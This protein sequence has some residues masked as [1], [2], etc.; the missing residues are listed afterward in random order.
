M[1]RKRLMILIWNLG[2]GGMQKRVRDMV[3]DISG[4][5]PDW[6]VHVL[7]R[8]Y[9]PRLFNEE[10]ASFNRVYVRYSPVN[11]FFLTKFS[12]LPWVVWEYFKIGPD[13]CLTFLSHLSSLL[14]IA[15]LL[16]FWKK[17]RLV[18][19]EGILTSKFLQ[20]HSK[21]IQLEEFFVRRLYALAD[22]II[23]PTV[24]IKSE[25]ISTYGLYPGLILVIPNWT[26]FSKI[27]PLKPQ[28][29]LIYAGRFETEKNLL[30]VIDLVKDLKRI[31]PDI[32]LCLIGEGSQERAIERAVVKKGLTQNVTIVDPQ[33]DIS[34]FLRKSKIFIILSKNEGLPNVILEAAMAQVPSIVSNF[35]GVNELI[36]HH[37]T[38]FIVRSSQDATLY[39]SMLLDDDKLRRYIGK[40]A[41]QQA[42]KK[43]S[44]RNQQ[45][46]I[47][48][49]IF[50]R[51]SE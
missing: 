23:V 34:P 9:F 29:D 2:I 46:F 45:E 15:K 3:K 6:E 39:A 22:K 20:I 47:L 44:H 17:S 1:K 30:R 27:K 28:F 38:G 7:V 4:N 31:K 33:K 43:F 35:D 24:A 51:K 11:N 49:G 36:E 5:Y 42:V 37:K 41:Q 26:L 50:N 48:Q 21:N 40:Q 25:L 10:I 14:V 19:N 12:K 8:D 16:I 32:S 13:V 18:L